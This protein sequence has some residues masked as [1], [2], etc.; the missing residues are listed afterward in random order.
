MTT[1]A[2]LKKV[3]MMRQL[4][5]RYYHLQKAGKTNDAHKVLRECKAL[6]TQVDDELPTQ[7]VKCE[8]PKLF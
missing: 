3:A 7:I 5:K 1:Q 6:E 2:F 4:Q 8:T